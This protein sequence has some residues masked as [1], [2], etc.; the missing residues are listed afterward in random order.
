MASRTR[1]ATDWRS[2][3]STVLTVLIAAMLSV[4]A[5][6]AMVKLGTTQRQLKGVLIVAAGVAMVVAATRPEVGLAMLLALM[7][8]EFHFSGT[9]TNEVVIVA[10]SLV[11]MWRIVA[12]AIPGWIFT[13]GIA[14]VLGSFAAVPGAVDQTNAFWGA[15][16]WL[17]AVLIL[18]AAISVLRSRRDASRRMIDIFTGSAVVVVLFAFAQ[19]AG[20]YVLVGSPYFSGHP[21]SFFGIYTVYA[22]YV[23]MAAVLATGEV[24]IAFNKRRK[25][26]ASVYGGA[27]VVILIGIAISTSRGGLLALGGG[28][29][30]LLLLNLRRGTIFIQACVVLVIFLGAG[31]L[32]TPHSTVA[33]IQQRLTEKRSASAEDKTRFALQKAGEQ[34]LVSHPFGLGYLNFP[35]YLRAHVRDDAIQKVFAHAH[36][37]PVEIGLDAGW[38]GLVG[39]LILWGWPI[40]KVLTYR[41]GGESAVRASAFAAALGG[42]MA[43]GLFDYL[44]YEI[45]VLIFFLAMVWGVIHSLSVDQAESAAADTAPPSSARLL[46]H[47]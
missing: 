9:G 13:G 8:F 31:F 33:T 1:S 44:F 35:F 42:F 20:V 3:R 39:F 46:S 19:K 24:V 12:S 30:L 10:M 18:Y 28:W 25:L 2:T 29:L 38:L 6:L 41:S 26:R 36:E 11:L 40:V 14:L 34:A 7:P 43:Q 17:A 27:L 15:I 22:G 47:V 32:A 21:N 23:A 5:G 45:D 16:R 37:T 4:L